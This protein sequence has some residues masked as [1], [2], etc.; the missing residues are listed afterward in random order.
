LNGAPATLHET[1][2]GRRLIWRAATASFAGSREKNKKTKLEN[3]RFS[4]P[5]G[6]PQKAVFV[7]F[8]SVDA[9]QGAFNATGQLVN[10]AALARA[11]NR[12]N[13]L[14]FRSYV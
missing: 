11:S 12:M 10:A 8:Q 9:A 4:A 6:A 13:A 5:K 7:A 3:L 2:W 1:T 14:F